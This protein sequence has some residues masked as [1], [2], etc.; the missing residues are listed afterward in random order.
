MKNGYYLV[1]DTQRDEL[2]N[3]DIA[4]YDQDTDSWTF[5]GDSQV[6]PNNEQHQGHKRWEVIKF[7]C[8]PECEELT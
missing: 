6:Y 7:I 2:T 1:R 3:R 4:A 8:D 5:C